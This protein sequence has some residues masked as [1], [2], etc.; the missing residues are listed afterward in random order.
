[1]L[2][3][4]RVPVETPT[5]FKSLGLAPGEDLLGLAHPRVAAG[6]AM[7]DVLHALQA[8]RN[9]LEP[10]ARAVQPLVGEA[11]AAL[12]RTPG[13]RLARMSGSGATVF[14][15]YDDCTTAAAAAKALQRGQ[16][17]W[18]IKATSLR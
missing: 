4:P 2:V 15:L 11:L 10:P 6:A 12:A 7:P 1:V 14:A 17:G 16:P 5:V 3:N 9:D 8:A 13:C 18:W